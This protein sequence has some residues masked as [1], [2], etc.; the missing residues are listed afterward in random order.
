MCSFVISSHI[1]LMVFR[2]VYFGCLAT[3]GADSWQYSCL[4]L[5]CKH[6]FEELKFRGKVEIKFLLKIGLE[7]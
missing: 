7:I 4:S 6:N 2:D 5:F 3:A 1:G